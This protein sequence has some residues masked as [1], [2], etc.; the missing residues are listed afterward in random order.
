MT[1]PKL[2]SLYM[3]A[4]SLLV[5]VSQAEFR[6]PRSAFTVDTVEEARQKAIEEGKGLAFVITNPAS[7]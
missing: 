6:V 3:V 4:A 2:F 5:S 7:R 1:S